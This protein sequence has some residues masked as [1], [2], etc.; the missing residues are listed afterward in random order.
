MPQ[1]DRKSRLLRLA[2]AN[3]RSKLAEMMYLKTGLDF[4]RPVQIYALPTMRCNAKCRMCG[5]WQIKDNTELPAAVWIRALRYLRRFVGR[6]HIQ[7]SA[8]EPLMKDD[9]FE[10]LDHCG[11]TGISAGVTTN[12]LLLT[13]GN[14]RRILDCNLFNVNVSVDSLDSA[15][16]DSIRGVPGTLKKVKGNIADLAAAREAA[17]ADL[18]IILRPLVCAETLSGLHG[19]VQYASDMGLTGVNF[20]PVGGT[21]EEVK[22]MQAVDQSLLAEAIDRLIDM[23]KRGYPIINSEP[24]MRRWPKYFRGEPAPPQE[25]RCVVVLRNL[26]ILTNGDVLTC[27]R[28]ESRIGNIA[29]QDISRMWRCEKAR[30]LRAELTQCRELCTETCLEKRRWRDYL[31]LFRKFIR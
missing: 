7:F 26:T 23:K 29:D 13:A 24:A 14:V 15:V 22:R 27:G 1:I 20:Q 10:I 18:K 30:R 8:A 2:A 6:Y 12:G 9:I 25:S 3:V 5:M 11:R 19:I 16:H 21:T 31:A 17:G 28:R 4:T